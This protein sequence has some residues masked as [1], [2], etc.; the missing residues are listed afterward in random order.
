MLEKVRSAARKAKTTLTEFHGDQ[1]SI[2]F[3]L[4][5]AHNQLRSN[6]IQALRGTGLH[7]GHVAILGFL[8]QEENLS[9]RE[10]GIKTG[11]EKSSMVIFLDQLES[12][13]WLQ[14]KADP[15][16]RRAY[17]VALT[18]EGR[19]RLSTLGPKLRGV[20]AEFLKGLSFQEQNRLRG[21]LLRIAE[22]ESVSDM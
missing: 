22:N 18:K 19:I 15:N 5:R 8:E 3:L 20:Q 9:Q 7:P 13:G 2:G 12:K 14:R 21:F 1:K 4:Q 10:L 6:L 11:I 17:A 16:D